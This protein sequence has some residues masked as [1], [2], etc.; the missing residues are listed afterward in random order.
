[1]SETNRRK[2]FLG[3]SVIASSWW[4]PDSIAPMM[5]AAATAVVAMVIGFATGGPA[6][7]A[8]AMALVVGVWLLLFRKDTLGGS[9][10]AMIGPR[11]TRWVLKRA[12]WNNFDPATEDVPAALG[13]VRVLAQSAREGGAELAIVEHLDEGY[14]SAVVWIR[15]RAGGIQSDTQANADATAFG[16]FLNGLAEDDI[17]VSQIDLTVRTI[18]ADSREYLSWGEPL[19]GRVNEAL[20]DAM[21][22]Q[23]DS[24]EVNDRYLSWL[25]IKMP[26]RLLSQ[27]ADLMGLDP[28]LEAVTATAFDVV[29]DVARRAAT[30]GLQPTW[31]MPPRT[32]GALLRHVMIPQYQPEDLDGIEQ[33]WDGLRF[34]YGLEDRGLALEVLDPAQ[35]FDTDA[36]A[37]PD[38]WYHAVGEIPHDGWPKSTVDTGWLESLVIGA[39]VAYR[40]VCVSFP[41]VPRITATGRARTAVA[42]STAEEVKDARAG[43]VSTG[44]EADKA[45]AARW[46]MT[47]I[48]SGGSSGV[49][50]TLR[51]MVSAPTMRWLQ[52]ARREV[53]AKVRGDLGCV[54]W[55][56]RD[57]DHTRA[58]MTMLPLARG[59]KGER[60]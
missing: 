7:G 30:A 9:A 49:T 59:V 50:P 53:E 21:R 15:G 39:N 24:I 42:M 10:A 5:I 1:M 33:V 43:K 4:S 16:R 2:F 12:G 28:G 8:L 60:R 41:L 51:V 47:D 14:M 54:K 56:W 19:W 22:E 35:D 55:T 27:R 57:H 37:E 13:R 25:T 20:A 52:T 48:V 18:P 40:T 11:V 34:E 3:G 45:D 26:T 32:L 46:M 17:P 58:L 31:G 38:T 36:A 29:G 23:S 44:V 6:A